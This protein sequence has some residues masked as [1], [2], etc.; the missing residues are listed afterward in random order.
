M[1]I[2]NHSGQTRASQAMQSSVENSQVMKAEPRSSAA[3]SQSLNNNQQR[4]QGE[5]NIEEIQW[6]ATMICYPYG[7]KI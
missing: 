3:A 5:D 4:N 2:V 7:S 1:N 6:R